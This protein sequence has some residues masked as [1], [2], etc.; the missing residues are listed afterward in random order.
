MEM[1]PVESPLAELFLHNLWANQ[2]LLRACQGLSDEQLGAGAEGTYGS[3]R[4]T[5]LH[6][7]SGEEDYLG[8]LTGEPIAQSIY[9]NPPATVAA[10][11]ERAATIG[12]ALARAAT[13][14]GQD[15]TFPRSYQGRIY[16][17]PAPRFLVQVLTHSTEHRTHVTTIQTQLGIEPPD[18]SG[19]A[20][21]MAMGLE[22]EPA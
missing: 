10:L 13:R 12:E 1:T 15:E 19:W 3:I 18:L 6:I 2:Q 16:S 11:R 17:L 22:S 7:V 4:D 5:L 14:V 21:I 20:Y 9:Q 8:V